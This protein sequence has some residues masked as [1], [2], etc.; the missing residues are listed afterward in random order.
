MSL[1]SRLSQG[2]N[3][4]RLQNKLDFCAYEAFAS[5]VFL[6]TLMERRRRGG[7]LPEGAREGH[8]MTLQLDTQDSGQN[9]T[10]LINLQQGQH[11]RWRPDV[12]FLQWSEKR[13][14]LV[15]DA[16]ELEDDRQWFPST[17]KTYN[18]STFLVIPA[19]YKLNGK[20][21]IV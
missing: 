3:A 17:N 19:L 7:K 9:K 20:T 18:N 10:N 6:I 15:W 8:E 14:G 21:R 4:S 13:D 5:I 16:R 12:C 11:C 1:Q 2:G